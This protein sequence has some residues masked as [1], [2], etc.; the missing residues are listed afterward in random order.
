EAW[1]RLQQRDVGIVITDWMMPGIDGIDLCKMIRSGGFPWYVYTILLT[2]RMDKADLL[3]GLEAG[4]DDFVGKP[5]SPAELRARVRNGHRI[6]SLE[7][8]LRKKNLEL[9]QSY[10]SL[11]R[12]HDR[13]TGDLQAA[14]WLQQRLLPP[15]PKTLMG[16]RF[17]ALFIPC[18]FVAG[19]IFNFFPISEDHI[20]FFM[21]DVSG[22]GV[23]SAMLSL[24]ISKIITSAPLMETF[25]GLSLQANLSTVVALEALNR[26]FES[27]NEIMGKY[28][29]MVL[30]TLEKSTGL[31]RF[32]LAGHPYPVFIPANGKPEFVGRSGSPI[33][34]LS[35]VELEES[36][37][38]LAPGDRILLYSDGMTECAASSG[39]A[40][41]PD[42]LMRCICDPETPLDEIMKRSALNLF[43]FHGS[44]RFDDDVSLLIFERME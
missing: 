18:H 13:L 29:T 20:A 6:Y 35:E 3:T 17:D 36:S 43:R 33:G 12:V 19:D 32:T 23:A 2:S 22:H 39:E 25:R 4:A 34:L 7:R 40:F 15:T 24:S 41:G 30:G 38:V 28:F 37:V 21:V 8:D 27:N 26:V 16:Y 44:D 14:A 31:C 42:R 1:E 10:N 5:F 11:Q 9:E